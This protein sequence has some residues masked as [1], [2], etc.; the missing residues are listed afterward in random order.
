MNFDNQGIVSETFLRQRWIL[1]WVDGVINFT[2]TYYKMHCI[3]M[4]YTLPPP[5]YWNFTKTNFWQG[6]EVWTL[7]E[8]AAKFLD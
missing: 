7:V 4:E 6:H 3:T 8:K 1:L 5:K 2:E